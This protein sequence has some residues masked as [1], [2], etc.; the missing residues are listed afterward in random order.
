MPRWKDEKNRLMELP[1]ERSK[2][3]KEYLDKY[4]P[5]AVIRGNDVLDPADADAILTHF[6]GKQYDQQGMN[7]G[8]LRNHFAIWCLGQKGMT[9][10]A[11]RNASREDMKG[12]FGEYKE[13]VLKHPVI[14]PEA[15]R[16]AAWYGEIYGKAMAN[17]KNISYPKREEL[18]GVEEVAKTFNSNVS[19]MSY[20][21]FLYMYELPGALEQN[22]DFKGAFE[23]HI[24]QENLDQKCKMLDEYFLCVTKILD[25]DLSVEE[26]IMYKVTLEHD[27]APLLEGKNV[28][29]TIK[30]DGK[31]I[32]NGY[33]SNT[34]SNVENFKFNRI[35]NL[36]NTYDS[37][38]LMD[39]SF[40]QIQKEDPYLADHITGIY[41]NDMGKVRAFQGVKRLALN[42]LEMASLDHQELQAAF[43]RDVDLTELNLSLA[44]RAARLEK[45]AEN[46]KKAKAY[47]DEIREIG[48]ELINAGKETEKLK[49][50]GEPFKSKKSPELL[51]EAIHKDPALVEESAK[52]FDR[53]FGKAITS[54]DALQKETD[55]LNTETSI[56]D[57]FQINGE[58]VGYF[59]RN[60]MSDLNIPNDAA[61]R[62]KLQKAVILSYMSREDYRVDFVPLVYRVDGLVYRSDEEFY[63]VSHP[64]V[65]YRTRKEEA[66]VLKEEQKKA[67]DAKKFFEQE[68][69]K[70]REAIEKHNQKH[71]KAAAEWAQ[72]REELKE[73][74]K[75][76]TGETAIAEED[77]YKKAYENGWKK[78]E[79][80]AILKAITEWCYVERDKKEVKKDVLGDVLHD[81]LNVPLPEG[82]HYYQ[83]QKILK[84]AWETMHEKHAD[85]KYLDILR[86]A[87]KAG[88][89][90]AALEHLEEDRDIYIDK[91][92]KMPNVPEEAQVFMRRAFGAVFNKD[93]NLNEELLRIRDDIIDPEADASV[94]T[95]LAR[96]LQIPKEERSEY[97]EEAYQAVLE[98]EKY[99]DQQYRIQNYHKF[100]DRQG[101]NVVHEDIS[102]TSSYGVILQAEKYAADKE[103]YHTLID[104]YEK[105][106]DPDHPGIFAWTPGWSKRLT[107]HM[108]E[109]ARGL[110]EASPE[111]EKKQEYLDRIDKTMPEVRYG[112]TIEPHE[113]AIKALTGEQLEEMGRMAN[114]AL[115]EGNLD[116][117]KREALELLKDFSEY[118]DMI[119]RMQADYYKYVDKN[120]SVQDKLKM[121]GCMADLDTKLGAYMGKVKDADP[122]MLAV[123]D[124][125]A[126]DKA[127]EFKRNVLKQDMRAYDDAVFAKEQNYFADKASGF[128]WT[129]TKEELRTLYTL[130]KYL[131][132]DGPQKAASDRCLQ[133][134]CDLPKGVERNGERYAEILK[135]PKEEDQFTRRV[136]GA[137]FAKSKELNLPDELREQ[138]REMKEAVFAR[139]DQIRD[140]IRKTGDYDRNFDAPKKEQEII[141]NNEPKKEQENIV[142]NE[143]KKEEKIIVNDEPKKEEKIIV[144][145]EPKKEKGIIVNNEPEKEQQ[146]RTDDNSIIR[147]ETRGSEADVAVNTHGFEMLDKPEGVILTAEE[148][149]SEKDR[150]AIIKENLDRVERA[151]AGH[152]NSTEYNRMTGKL[153]DLLHAQDPAEYAT[154]KSELGEEARKYLDHTGLKVAKH[155]NSEIR[156]KCA[157]L[158]MAYTDDPYY[159]NYATKANEKRSE[160]DKISVQ[161]LT[162]TEGIG[163][164][165]ADSV[166]NRRSLH[167]LIEDENAANAKN[168]NEQKHSG[169]S[170][171]EKGAAKDGNGFKKK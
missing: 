101:W 162:S 47:R 115:S 146:I 66:E 86:E 40:L 3:E 129:M 113:A 2:R 60:K 159:G 99:R 95:Y 11:F 158:L 156:R 59:L 67:E 124:K 118:K 112:A 167:D 168:S 98:Y 21:G 53:I 143:P 14:G 148:T 135:N 97:Q 6:Y 15:A 35:E 33:F 103:A 151:Y 69:E 161:K 72:K 100:L 91:L 110:I 46:A 16:H 18:A 28:L 30:V 152:T 77:F 134:L 145:D 61:Y 63:P 76:R 54:Q 119:K 65:K 49:I 123:W 88:T 120:Y 5:F 9:P 90:R 150:L 109:K 149:Q 89:G 48:E 81:I 12:L 153:N 44:R 83:R 34:V 136:I 163:K 137:I 138:L 92:Q 165:K 58:I 114:R 105:G 38:R 126:P 144:N 96:I 24:S 39:Q 94:H 20:L 78:E 107:L 102:K 128:K 29:D 42:E 43:R 64:E 36:R 142:N 32:D 41:Q 171:Q 37:E 19:L 27:L 111:Y 13:E 79:D 157:F 133:I 4:H 93:G 164:R 104:N 127:A 154:L 131:P 56:A 139:A 50:A 17:L 132:Q 55:G 166:R 80:E 70:D 140:Q 169:R 22:A 121:I 108:L 125:I 10:E 160:E 106:F 26:R 130:K 23:K 84:Q 116:P 1:E 141:A 147:I 57:H 75:L 155:D 62:E 71:E 7:I 87:V 170:A 25:T 74:L 73:R 31:D 122:E 68:D 52:E 45:R 8:T 51:I 117:A 82:E 85:R